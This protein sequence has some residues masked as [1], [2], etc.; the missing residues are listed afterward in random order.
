M[1]IYANSAS[2]P[3]IGIR[4]PLMPTCD[5]ELSIKTKPRHR[6]LTAAPREDLALRA[7]QIPGRR[8]RCPRLDGTEVGLQV[9]D[10][11]STQALRASGIAYETRENAQLVL[12]KMTHPKA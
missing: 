2:N 6:T 8:L 10:V 9:L 4:T 5:G 11:A 1:L 3:G 12:T 7:S